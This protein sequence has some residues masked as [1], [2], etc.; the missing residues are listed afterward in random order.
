MVIGFH[1]LC[2]AE[3]VDGHS[4]LL[5]EP[6]SVCLSFVRCLLWERGATFRVHRQIMRVHHI[7]KSTRIILVC[8]VELSI[9]L[10]NG[11]WFTYVLYISFSFR[12]RHF[13]IPNND[14]TCSFPLKDK[15]KYFNMPNIVWLCYISLRWNHQTCSLHLITLQTLW[16]KKNIHRTNLF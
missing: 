16:S 15:E 7:R 3:G 10:K 6:V 8:C 13:S 11:K 1:R 2:K 4:P 9:S 12:H 14:Q 5:P